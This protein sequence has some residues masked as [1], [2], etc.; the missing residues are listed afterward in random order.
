MLGVGCPG[1]LTVAKGGCQTVAPDIGTLGKMSRKC[2]LALDFGT[3]LDP[4]KRPQNYVKSGFEV[5]LTVVL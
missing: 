3:G 1:G 4:R 5:L 2:G